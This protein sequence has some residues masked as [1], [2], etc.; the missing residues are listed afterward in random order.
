MQ[1]RTPADAAGSWENA[2]TEAMHRVSDAVSE[3]YF[4]AMEYARAHPENAA[5]VALGVGVT[6]GCLLGRSR[7]PRGIGGGLLSSL[8]LAAGGAALDALRGEVE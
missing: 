3:C 5:F 1:S 7:S 2:T 6:V 8:A 4:R